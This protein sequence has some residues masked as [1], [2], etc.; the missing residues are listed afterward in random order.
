GGVPQPRDPSPD[1]PPRA[2]ARQR[3]LLPAGRH[4]L[5][6]SP[7]PPGLARSRPARPLRSRLT[8]RGRA[9]LAGLVIASV[10]AAVVLVWLAA[11]GGAQA[12]SNGVPPGSVK[13]SMTQVV[14]RPGQTL[15]AIALRV[16]PGADPRAVVQEIV[17]ANGLPGPS[18]QPGERL[19][20]PKA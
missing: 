6:S 9:L 18:I 10:L 20:V 3:L 19:W 5:S 17:D 7:A 13:R 12:A 2:S 11:A 16:Q 14:V 15:W 4:P 8:R 1:G